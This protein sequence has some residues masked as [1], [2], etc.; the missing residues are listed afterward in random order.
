M[1]LTGERADALWFLDNIA[2]IRL[3]GEEVGEHFSIVEMHGPAGHSP[4]LHR[5]LGVDEGFYV[6]EGDLTFYQPGRSARLGRGDFFLAAR[7]VPHTFRVGDAP[8]RWLAI[9]APAGFERF[10]AAVAE[11]ARGSGFP[12]P[13]DVPPDPEKLSQ[14]ATR[15]GIEILGPPGTLP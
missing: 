5:H 10:V 1:T 11:P 3:R 15:F 4:P 7:D 2:S 13:P 9:C 14:I 12:P 8:G 6:L